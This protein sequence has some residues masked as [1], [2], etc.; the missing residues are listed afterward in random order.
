MDDH[1]TLP[2]DTTQIDAERLYVILAVFTGGLAANNGDLENY[3]WLEFFQTENSTVHS[4][5]SE[6]YSDFYLI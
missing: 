5:F 1:T 3:L 2:K 4:C 6:N